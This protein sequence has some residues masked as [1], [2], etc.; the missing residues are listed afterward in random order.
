[1]A[2]AAYGA[3]LARLMSGDA[4]GARRSFADAARTYRDSWDG[5]PPGSWGRMIGA[6]K[7]NLLAGDAD[8]AADAARWTLEHRAAE[9]ESAI[10]RY[11]ATLA[12]LVLG[13]DADARLLA[14]ELRTHDEFPHPVGDALAYVAGDDP[15]GYDEAI[16]EV[17]ESFE[18]R[19]EYLEDVPVAD[20]VLALQAL[21][22]ARGIVVALESPVLPA[23]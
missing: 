6:L 10:G 1:M 14:D 19:E 9:A 21:A 12:L 3:A 8:A 22:R 16:G 7:A 5:A 20:T 18:T 13:R 11:A 15:L 17:L 4:D 2:N 23:G